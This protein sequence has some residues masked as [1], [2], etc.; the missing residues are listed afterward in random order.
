M[1]F[2]GLM[3]GASYVNVFYNILQDPDLRVKLDAIADK[4]TPAH[5]L[6][7]HHVPSGRVEEGAST[8]P[9][10]ATPT[11]AHPAHAKRLNAK[12][13]AM[14]VGALYATLGITMGSVLDLI[15]GNTLMAHQGH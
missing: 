10:G 5:Q 8:D 4:H 2:V 7:D 11:A 6:Y 15:L 14:N 1:V 12:E 13:L 9:S 3:G